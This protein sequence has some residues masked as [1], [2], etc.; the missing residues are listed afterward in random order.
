LLKYYIEQGIK[1][2]QE[3]E[4]G[5]DIGGVKEREGKVGAGPGIGRD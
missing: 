4:E 2:S 3:V 5:K 1:Q